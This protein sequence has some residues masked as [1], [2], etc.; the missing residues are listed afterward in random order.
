MSCRIRLINLKSRRV[1]WK[2]P[3]TGYLGVLCV[4]DPQVALVYAECILESWGDTVV[5]VSGVDFINDAHEDLGGILVKGNK[6][7]VLIEGTEM[8]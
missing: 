5:K 7:G 1:W 3:P 8:L 4:D 6:L 2:N